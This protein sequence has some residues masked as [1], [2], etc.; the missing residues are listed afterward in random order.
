MAMMAPA[1]LV[2]IGLQNP[3][4]RW[5]VAVWAA[6]QIVQFGALGYS[7]IFTGGEPIIGVFCWVFFARQYV[8]L[9]WSAV[10]GC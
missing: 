1:A 4:K 3:V 2:L 9:M 5:M 6:C 8:R 7:A 10:N